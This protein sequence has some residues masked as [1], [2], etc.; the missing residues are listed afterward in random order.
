MD[1]QGQL[2]FFGRRPSCEAEAGE[3]SVYEA[4]SY[5]FAE[6]PGVPI[7]ARIT[8]TFHGLR[9][10][11]TGA[12]SKISLSFGSLR[13]FHERTNGAYSP[14]VRRKRGIDD[15]DLPTDIP[16]P[17]D[18]DIISSVVEVATSKAVSVAEAAMDEIFEKASALTHGDMG[19]NF[20]IQIDMNPEGK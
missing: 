14:V 1:R 17:T 20:D 13:A 16:I 6:G 11:S 7:A 3:R 12:A 9:W 19:L 4:V 5:E 8:A 18:P 2:A 15:I 10:H